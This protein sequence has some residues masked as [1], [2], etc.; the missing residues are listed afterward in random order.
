MRMDAS[1]TGSTLLSYGPSIFALQEAKTRQWFAK[2][3][4]KACLQLIP[5]QLLHSCCVSMDMPMPMTS[6]QQLTY[7]ATSISRTCVVWPVTIHISM[8]AVRAG[9]RHLDC[10]RIA[11]DITAKCLGCWRDVLEHLPAI[12]EVVGCVDGH[13]DGQ[14]HQHQRHAPHKDGVALIVS[15]PVLVGV[16]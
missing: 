3:R 11:K 12:V 9:S 2:K 16:R 14:H 10:V 15:A 1:R 7:W 6:G 8:H 4:S 5:T 13:E